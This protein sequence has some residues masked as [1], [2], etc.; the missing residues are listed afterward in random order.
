MI[1]NPYSGARVA[2]ATMHGKER[3][4]RESF[5]DI[6]G[7]E[8]VAVPDLDTDQFGAF[9]GEIA[10]T[11][12]PRAAAS[13]KARLGMQ[14]AGTPYGLASEGSF[15]AGLGFVTEHHEVLIFIDETLGLELVEGAIV[16]SP[17]PPGRTITSTDEGLGY[18]NAVGFPEQGVLVR[19]GEAGKLI[20]KNV[21]SADS[22]SD[23]LNELLGKSLN[24]R[25]GPVTISPDY[26]SHRCPSRAKVIAGLADTMARRL[27]T[28]CPQCHICGFGHV[29]V[30]RGLRCADC[31]QPTRVIAAEIDGCGACSHTVRNPRPDQ[32]ASPQWCDFCNP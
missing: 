17:L 6:L 14:L 5:R 15:D 1:T 18:A 21:E 13:A 27:A 10:R 20:R 26:R 16:A 22:L 24:A 19:G 4:A 31:G 28:P 23:A 12:S 7:A 25:G 3:L 30:E 11:L 29:D 8:V 32:R 9:S 2:F